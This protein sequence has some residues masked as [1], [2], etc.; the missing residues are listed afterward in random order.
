MPVKGNESWE[1]YMHAGMLFCA[2]NYCLDLTFLHAAQCNV[3]TMNELTLR[4]SP[5]T[6]SNN[7]SIKLISLMKDVFLLLQHVTQRE[8]IEQM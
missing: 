5:G 1:V 4:L 7:I 8:E 3:N 6:S 2:G